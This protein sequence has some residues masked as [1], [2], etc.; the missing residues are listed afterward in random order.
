M[1]HALARGFERRGF[2]DFDFCKLMLCLDVLS[3]LGI[4]EYA[5][6]GNVNITFRDTQSKKNLADSRTWRAVGGE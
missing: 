1:P 3:E 5:Y 6:N 2:A 4:I